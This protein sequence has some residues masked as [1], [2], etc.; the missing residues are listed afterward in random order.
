MKEQVNNRKTATRLLLVQWARFQNEE[1]RLEGSTLITG[2]NGTGKSTL[3]DAMTYLLTGNKQFNKAARDKDRTVKG[4]VRG[5]TKSNGDARYLRS[6]AV[7]SYI[8]MEFYSPVDDNYLV[9]GVCM[10]SPD[11]ISGLGSYWFVRRDAR[12]EDF[13]FTAVEGRKLAVTPKSGLTCHGKRLK[14]GD[15]MGMERGTEQ[16]QRALGLRCDSGKY[17]SKLVK[18]MAF[19]PENNIDQFIAECVLEPGTVNSLKELREQR[20]QFDQIRQL[21]VDLSEGKK[22]LEEIEECSSDYEKSKRNLEIRELM[23]L[24]QS[25]LEMQEE[26]KINEQKLQQAKSELHELRLREKSMQ[27]LIETVR[28]RLSAAES[29]D[30]FSG[31]QSSIVALEEQIRTLEHDIEKEQEQTAVLLNLQNKLQGELS[32]IETILEKEQSTDGRSIELQLEVLHHLA[33]PGYDV[34]EKR[35]NLH[36]FLQE[37]EH[38]SE[39]LAEE[40]VHTQDQLRKCQEDA[41]LYQEQIRLLDSNQLLF[42]EEVR[43]GKEV[44]SRELL[45]RGIKTD[46][47]TFAELVKTVKDTAW[48]RAIETFLGRKRYY[49]IVDG[50][51]A[52]DAMEILQQQR[53]YR[54]N[55][56]ITDKLPDTEITMGSAAEQLE[57]PNIYAR[58]YANYLLNGIHLCDSLEEL[59]NHPKGGLMKDGMLAKSYAAHNMN[60]RKTEL[61]LGQDA[62]RHQRELATKR[63]KE[64]LQLL[65]EL[66]ARREQLRQQTRQLRDIDLQEENYILGSP[67]LLAEHEQQ[68]KSCQENLEQIRNNPDFV[69]VLKEQEYAKKAY[70]DATESGN[71]LQ[72]ELGEKDSTIRSLE[73][74]AKTISGQ[75]L[76][77]DKKY[78]EQRLSHLELEKSMLEE[79]EKLR[80]KK[81][82][83]I[84]LQEK[85]VI[86]L[87][88]ELDQK[89]HKLENEQL[90]YC[91]ISGIDTNRRGVGY[92]PFY[93]EE[94]RNV[95]NVKIEEAHHRLQEQSEKLENAFMND[96]V[97]E[98]NETITEAKKE[99]DNINREL[100][101]IPFGRDTYQFRMEERPDRM[102][103]F[104]ICKKLEE[105]MNSPSAYMSLHHDDEEMQRDI[106]EFMNMILEE[107]DEEQYT[108]YRKYFSYDMKIISRQGEAEIVSDLSKKQGSASGGEKQTP[109]FIIL[110]ASLMQCY[111]RS[112]CCERL[113]FIDEAFSAL[114]RE[115]IE[116]MVKYLEDNHFQV[117]YAAPPEKIGSIGQFITSTVSLVATDRYS[118]AV[119]GLELTGQRE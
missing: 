24:Y 40:M 54:I 39:K 96:F 2:V 103:F 31:M 58:R 74:G 102:L 72:Q 17:R 82:S 71:R 114:S 6:G 80:A 66:L 52:G 92:I 23:L 35:R 14:T 64:T 49:I 19:N 33:E 116:Q 29:N 21:Y 32:W 73:D 48:Q 41:A 99:I 93:R 53:L 108:D 98:M 43:Q 76:L 112:S 3:L 62:I 34:E 68:K 47:R 55:V 26:Q 37:A 104:R 42:P 1:I 61:C 109:Y 101:Q 77:R 36:V 70:Q 46:V 105:Y 81:D 51:Y 85:T 63:L 83:V 106:E 5:D 90:A 11:E 44:L 28:K 45:K 12:L 38:M 115:R 22:K 86:N 15:F 79:Y 60:I 78:Q 65:E 27:E 18:M 30:L 16:L 94:Y 10:E 67:K 88:G 117:I 69:A 113:A 20:D 7:V 89:V 97:A 95:A 75:I 100:K 25:L 50:Q 57:I 13:N 56:V 87:R 59:H 9:C 84:A 107:E 8:V 118:H 110:A 111:P 4:Y 91:Q 119:E